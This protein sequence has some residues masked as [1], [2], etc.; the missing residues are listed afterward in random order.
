MKGTPLSGRDG[1]EL[2]EGATVAPS[3]FSALGGR[4]VAGR[5]FAPTD[6]PT[7]PIVISDRLARRLFNDP[8]AAL[9]AHLDRRMCS[10]TWHPQPD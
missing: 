10:R 5:P 9:G 2:V 3:F 7:P 4:I 6:G 8:S 1:A